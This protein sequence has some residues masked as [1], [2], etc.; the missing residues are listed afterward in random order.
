MDLT[1]GIST[2]ASSYYPNYNNLSYASW[3]N[4]DPADNEYWMRVFEISGAVTGRYNISDGVNNRALGDAFQ[5]FGS[6][7]YVSVH[8][9]GDTAPTTRSATFNIEIC[10][11]ASGLPDGNWAGRNVTLEAIFNTDVVTPPPV[12]DTTGSVSWD[13]WFGAP[14]SLGTFFAAST[15]E[16][17][18]AGISIRFTIPIT[19]SAY[20]LS[21]SSLEVPFNPG[22]RYG[23]INQEV[24]N[25]VDGAT[26]SWGLGGGIT[27][28]INLAGQDIILEPG[29]T[30][31]FNIKTSNFITGFLNQVT[32]Q[33]STFAV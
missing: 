14:F 7:P 29:Q 15:G 13:S 2:E 19:S 22:I 12:V 32:L 6:G 33:A 21:M 28:G 27:G 16:I 23:A 20:K 8:T 18:A 9:F 26:Y 31:F 11:D 17:P 25:F 24:L 10:K 3:L 4:A 5:M 1:D 30:Y